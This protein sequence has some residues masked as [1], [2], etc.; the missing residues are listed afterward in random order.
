MDVGAYVEETA[1][2][3]KRAAA[4]MACASSAL[5]DEVLE[6]MACNILDARGELKEQNRRDL[7]AAR[8]A[9]LSD[10]L[11]DRLELT[12]K[13]IDGM[14]A[15][16]RKVIALPDPAGRI[17]DGWVRPNG[18]KVD[19]VRVPIGVICMIYESR[20]NVTADAASLCLKS[21]NAV[22]LRG[23]KE[24]MHSNLAIHRQFVKAC[25]NTSTW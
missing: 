22:I 14:A 2:A 9:G 23:G 19:R 11:L 4:R 25:V 20:P 6:R 17:M 1:A 5:K 13:R 8:E 15:S 16:I 10:A 12:D 7:D 24:A 3:A 18:L 21:G